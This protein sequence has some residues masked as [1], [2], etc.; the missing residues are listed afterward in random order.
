MNLIKCLHCGKSV[1][2]ANV[3]CPN[4]GKPVRRQTA[5]WPLFGIMGLLY[6]LLL[7]LGIY[8]TATGHNWGWLLLGSGILLL[9][10]R[11]IRIMAKR[12]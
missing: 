5:F 10:L 11:T 4:C 8:F 7:L 2:A 12:K 1:P 6:G 9:G 3:K